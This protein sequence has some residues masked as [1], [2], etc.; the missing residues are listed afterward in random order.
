MTIRLGYQ[1]LLAASLSVIGGDVWA[2]QQDFF[3]S[4]SP[5]ELNLAGLWGDNLNP[6]LSDNTELDGYGARILPKA[7]FAIPG[8]GWGFFVKYNGQYDRYFF[9]DEHPI[10]GDSLDYDFTRVKVQT[11][12]YLSDKWLVELYG[13]YRSEDERL[14]TGV[15][16]LREDVP[17]PDNW[18]KTEYAA[19]VIYGDENAGRYVAF[20]GSFIENDYSNNDY[21]DLF[22]LDRITL[23]VDFGFKLSDQWRF[24]ALVEGQDDDSVDPT[25]ADS[26]VITGL[27]GLDWKASGRS[28]FSGM[29]GGYRRKYADG[30]ANSGLSWQVRYIYDVDDSWQINLFSFQYSTTGEDEFALDVRRRGLDGRVSYDMSDYWQFGVD[31][32]SLN[33]KYFQEV[34]TREVDE[35]DLGFFALLSF[36]DYHDLELSV[37]RRHLDAEEDEIEYWQNEVTLNWRYMF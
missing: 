1:C 25:R 17:N 37:S 9:S 30:S 2:K 33:T 16:K 26:K 34:S 20:F 29:V 4:P 15:S 21:S 8:E 10:A 12:L 35:L 31:L 3:R 22:D 23:S 32:A 13:L 19:K 18:L 36:K 14:G 27:V 28:Q 7:Q 24:V 11:D 5:F 6:T